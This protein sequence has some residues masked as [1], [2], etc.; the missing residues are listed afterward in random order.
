VKTVGCLLLLLA[1]ALSC[2]CYSSLEADDAANES[3]PTADSPYHEVSFSLD[4]F[5]LCLSDFCY[6][7]ERVTI[8]LEEDQRLELWWYAYGD[9]REVYAT[10]IMPD[11][12]RCTGRQIHPDGGPI[13]SY[14]CNP[15]RW[16]FDGDPG[17]TGELGFRCSST[18]GATTGSKLYPPGDYTL[19][20]QVCGSASPRVDVHTSS[21]VNMLVKYKIR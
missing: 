8:H 12:T 3:P 6:D 4:P 1:I 13:E 20:F 2:G 16:G 15:R 9:T 19:V 21:E 14:P 11:G 10:L 18:Y 7:S 5:K 17:S